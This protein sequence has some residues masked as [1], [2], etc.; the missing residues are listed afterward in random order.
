VVSQVRLER[1]AG[2]AGVASKLAS[3]SAPDA[4]P[5]T[6]LGAQP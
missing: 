6:S 4:Q 1:S 3:G 5:S 2:G